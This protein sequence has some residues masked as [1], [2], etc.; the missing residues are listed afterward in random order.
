[1]TGE[2]YFPAGAASGRRQAGAPLLRSSLKATGK[3]TK[4]KGKKAKKGKVLSSKP[5]AGSTGPKGMKVKLVVGKQPS[6][7][8]LRLQ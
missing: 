5:S 8:L 2:H 4:K 1:V 6:L 7:S 3:V